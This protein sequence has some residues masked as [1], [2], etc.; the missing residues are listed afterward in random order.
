MMF[1]PTSDDF[2][3]FKTTIFRYRVFAPCKLG[4]IYIVNHYRQTAA[5]KPTFFGKKSLRGLFIHINEQ[6][7]GGSTIC[8]DLMAP[9][10]PGYYCIHL[11]EFKLKLNLR[12][13]FLSE[14]RFCTYKVP[15]WWRV[16]VLV[17]RIATKHYFLLGTILSLST[18]IISTF[19]VHTPRISKQNKT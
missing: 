8:K 19:F 16:I 7:E 4:E 15:S 6:S 12:N 9:G 5:P 10:E 2:E 18:L 3:C 11:F 13:D 1:K 14:L 17:V